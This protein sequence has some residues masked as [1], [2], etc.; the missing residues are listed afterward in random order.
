MIK[1]T[2]TL[3]RYHWSHLLVVILIRMIVLNFN[4]SPPVFLPKVSLVS[5]ALVCFLTS[6]GSGGSSN[7]T[8]PKE[9]VA[10]TFSLSSVLVNDCGVESPFIDIEL[11]HQDSNWQT[12]EVYPSDEN[13]VITFTTFDEN[14]NYTLVAK[15]QEG[16]SVEGLNI[17]SYHQA[18]TTTMSRYIARYD[19]K[20]DQS[21]CECL[22][23]DVELSHKT[24]N[25]ITSVTSSL[26]FESYDGVT[27]GK[28]QYNN[29]EIC[30]EIDGNWPLS[31]FAV[32]GTDVNNEAIGV[33]SFS[34]DFDANT[35]LVWTLSAF[36]DTQEVTLSSGHQAFIS[37][38]VIQ[39]KSHFPL[40][41]NED[42]TSVLLFN[43]HDYTSEA[44]Y[45]SQANVELAENS[46]FFGSILIA[47]SHSKVS[48]DA[49]VSFAVMASTVTPDIDEVNFSE[50]KADG[51]YD[52]SAVSGYPMAIISFELTTYHPITGL[53]MP[54]TWSNYGPEKSLLAISAP[55]TGYENIVDID[56]DRQVTDTV[57]LNSATSNGYQDYMLH[58]QAR[59]A[60]D[61]AHDLKQYH[62]SITR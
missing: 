9:P 45:R 29:V 10:M 2:L 24:M 28:T 1:L 61:F 19:Q 16:E 35:E 41:V 59:L 39:G 37:E 14:I 3:Q 11:L 8:S 23:K 5:L 33:A 12:L 32:V 13:G 25:S 4:I 48:P 6:C 22:I 36:D 15:K 21:S 55:L 31:S 58:F 17:E 26:A 18:K 57:L 62:I 34:D 46:S 7:S 38:Q 42:Q 50:I 40:T 52:Y 53:P 43:S 30:R 60:D 54:T 56:T 51:S 20:Q 27:S 47:S 49:D 44:L